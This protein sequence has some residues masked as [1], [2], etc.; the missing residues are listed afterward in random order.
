MHRQCPRG[1]QKSA[2]ILDQESSRCP[3]SLPRW[4]YQCVFSPHFNPN[5]CSSPRSDFPRVYSGLSL[6]SEAH[7]SNATGVI[8]QASLLPTAS[9]ESAQSRISLS[10]AEICRTPRQKSQRSLGASRPLS[11]RALRSSKHMLLFNRKLV[12]GTPTQQADTLQ[13]YFTTH[14]SFN[15]PLCVVYPSA[16]S[17]DVWIKGIYTWYK[18]MSPEPQHTIDVHNVC[19][20]LVETSEAKA[21]ALIGMRCR[22]R[23][24]DQ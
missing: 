23:P 19:V 17:R 22:V 14:A 4:R 18:I 11:L 10:S 12:A 8:S 24:A 16:H 1:H 20:S 7:L 2:R 13:R 15:H 6:T 5:R 9:P 21:S 3:E